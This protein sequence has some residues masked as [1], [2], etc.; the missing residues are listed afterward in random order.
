MLERKENSI[1]EHHKSLCIF[2]FQVWLYV[3][4]SIKSKILV[5]ALTIFENMK[6]LFF[7][8]YLNG[9]FLCS[10]AQL[11]CAWAL[12][13]MQDRNAKEELPEW[14]SRFEGVFYNYFSIGEGFDHSALF[15][16][17]SSL[18]LS[19]C[20]SKAS[21]LHHFICFALNTN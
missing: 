20:S 13:L 6:N 14:F 21:Y 17:I 8:F 12:I 4:L 19:S 18:L 15:W 16:F 11:W 10:N 1:H 9:K 7:F 3:L 5:A 2:I